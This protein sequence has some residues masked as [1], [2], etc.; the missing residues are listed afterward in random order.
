[1]EKKSFFLKKKKAQVSC[2]SLRSACLHFHFE[3]QFGSSSF[4]I[5]EIVKSLEGR[6]F[7]NIANKI[8]LKWVNSVSY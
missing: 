5:S 3:M 4:Y 1:M 6:F 2:A 7:N 8:N